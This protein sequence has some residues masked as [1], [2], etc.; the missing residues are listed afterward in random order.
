MI[1]GYD[2]AHRHFF[3]YIHRYI[4]VDIHIPLNQHPR[5][6]DLK[7][8]PVVSQR[9]GIQLPVHM[10][11]QIIIKLNSALYPQISVRYPRFRLINLH[12]QWVIGIQSAAQ[13]ERSVNGYC[14]IAVGVDTIDNQYHRI[15]L[16]AKG[17]A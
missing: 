7:R 15:L 8:A 6:I 16:A 13:N 4:G 9:P 1:V 3:I 5:G 10:E 11:V 14:N 12:G 17:Y 2:L